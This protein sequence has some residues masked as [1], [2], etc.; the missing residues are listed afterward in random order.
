MANSTKYKRFGHKVLLKHFSSLS[1]I[2]IGFVEYCSCYFTALSQ[3][4]VADMHVPLWV[5]TL[6][7]FEIAIVSI[8]WMPKYFLSK[9]I[10]SFLAHQLT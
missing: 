10:L 3:Q 4:W 6:H 9:V 2:P 1:T 8:Q 7:V 5:R